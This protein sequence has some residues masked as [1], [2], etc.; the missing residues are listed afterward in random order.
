MCV[1]PCVRVCVVCS[2]SVLSVAISLNGELCFSGSTDSSIGVW[3][4]PSDL[5]DPFDVYG[6]SFY[7]YVVSSTIVLCYTIYSYMYTQTYYS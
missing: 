1:I 2:G 4:L 6:K 7:M 3:Q 5:S